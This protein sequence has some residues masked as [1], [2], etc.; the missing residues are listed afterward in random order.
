MN[1]WWIRYWPPSHTGEKKKLQTKSSNSSEIDAEVLE[2]DLML[3]DVYN[4]TLP[5]SVSQQCQ[6]LKPF[7]PFSWAGHSPHLGQWETRRII[8]RSVHP[9]LLICSWR[10]SSGVEF[11]S[12]GCGYPISGFGITWLAGVKF[13]IGKTLHV[14]FIGLFIG[15]FLDEWG[16]SSPWSFFPVRRKGNLTRTIAPWSLWSFTF[17]IRLLLLQYFSSFFR[18]TYWSG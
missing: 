3:S 10:Y 6:C 15:H 18:L 5:L 13:F 16:I 4:W 17:F 1:G 8:Q 11:L 14:Q 2:V 7:S 12:L 9:A